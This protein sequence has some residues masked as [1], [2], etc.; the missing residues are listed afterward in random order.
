MSGLLCFLWI[1]R[2]M[3]FEG[4]LLA[5]PVTAER[6]AEVEISKVGGKRRFA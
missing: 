6:L 5:P 3:L 2:D 1:K 4:P